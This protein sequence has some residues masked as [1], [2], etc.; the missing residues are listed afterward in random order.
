MKAIFEFTL[1]EEQGEYDITAAACRMH[2]GLCEFS[3][4][5]RKWRKYGYPFKTIRQTIEGVEKEFNEMLDTYSID[6]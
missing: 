2:C 3:A 1:P 4:Q 6:L 5:L